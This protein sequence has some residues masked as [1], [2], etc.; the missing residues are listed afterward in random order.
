M[1]SAT[2]KTFAGGGATFPVTLNQGGTGALTLTGAN[3]FYKITNSTQPTSIL[4]TPS[5]TTTLTNGFLV[6]GTS[7]NLVTIGTVGNTGTF[8]LSLAV[9]VGYGNYLSLSRSTATGGAFWYAGANST[10]GGNNTGWVFSTYIP[11]QS[12]FL[13]FFI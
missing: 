13:V 4:F 9:G 5:T 7:G 1:T 2:A 8:T 10:N 11:N 3:T 6:N 12:G